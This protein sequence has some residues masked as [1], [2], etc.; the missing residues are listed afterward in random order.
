MTVAPRD[1][2]PARRDT[3]STPHVDDRVAVA[4]L[5]D[6]GRQVRIAPTADGEG[7]RGQQPADPCEA[8]VVAVVVRCGVDAH[9]PDPDG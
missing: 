5:R 3:R 8:G 2:A 6:A 4:Q 7:Q 1:A 9:G